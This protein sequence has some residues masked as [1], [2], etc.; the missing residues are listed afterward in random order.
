MRANPGTAGLVLLLAI[1]C[2]APAQSSLAAAAPVDRSALAR[3]AL[4]AE[5]VAADVEFLASDE[6]AGRDTPSGG[7]RIAARYLV[8]RLERLGF[9]PGARDGWYHAFDLQRRRL[10]EDRATLS[11]GGAPLTYGRDF[12]LH[13]LEVVDGEWAGEVVFCGGGG[14]EDLEG[15]ELDGRW[16][17]CVTGTETRNRRRRNVERAGA[18]GLL[19]VEDPE[20]PTPFA[21]WDANQREGATTRPR[22]QR[23]ERLPVAWLSG[24]AAWPWLAGNPQPG[25]PLDVEVQARVDSVERFAVENVC[26]FWPGSDPDL[27]REVLLVSAHYDHIGV[28]D[29]E[30][31]NG[32]DDNASGTAGLLALAEALAAHGPLRRSVMLLWVT[33]EERGL[34]GSKAWVEDL[35]LPG[36]AEVVCDINLD[37]IGRNAPEFLEVTPTH[38]HPRTN[39]LG[40]L[41]AEFARGEGFAELASAD[42]D[43]TRSDHFVFATE[44]RVPVVY[45][46]GGEHAD[47]H[48]AT[49]TADKLD[50]DKIA[51]VMAVVLRLLEA[52]QDD[53]LRLLPEPPLEPYED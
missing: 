9:E 5:A 40:T 27:A 42:K 36:D 48:E 24:A 17:L 51:R 3:A 13:V 21:D 45:L 20:A 39:R 32:A 46:S 53:D 11:L 44:L 28:I 14:R 19:L 18:G 30:V 50:A 7:Q 31:Y 49:D 16:A 1:G 15:L 33:G 10:D 52:L 35:W 23:S 2:S 25:T 4:R 29:G 43:F 38:R 26:G 12:G 37:M 47:Y 34:L 6:L 41:A 22:P 8:N